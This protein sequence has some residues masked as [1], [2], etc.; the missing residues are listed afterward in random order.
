MEL[1]TFEELSQLPI[2][3]RFYSVTR[4]LFGVYM[5]LKG[6][7]MT[8]WRSL[9]PPA[10]P[11]HFCS[12]L[13]HTSAAKLRCIECGQ[14]H[15]DSVLETRRSISYKCHAGLTDFLIPIVIEDRIIAFLQ[16]GQVLDKRPTEQAWQQVR[17]RLKGLDLDYKKLRQSFFRITVMRPAD[18]KNLIELLEVFSNYIADT[19]RR[20]LLLERGRKSQIVELTEIFIREHYKEPITLD[21]IARAAFTSKRNLTRV[22]TAETGMT[23][24]EFIHRTRLEAACELLRNSDKKILDIAFECGFGSIQQFNRV[25]KKR[26]QTTPD[27]LRRPV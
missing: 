9:G 5:A 27:A 15:Q 3:H 22:F 4:K 23:V 11:D 10:A 19:G 21:Q 13:N 17:K 6:P 24:L 8:Q 25:F 26:M 2:L 16:C 18:Q 7:G 20:L 1:I 12:I 14:L